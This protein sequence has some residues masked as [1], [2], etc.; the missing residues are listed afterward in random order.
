M[1]YKGDKQYR[2][3][4]YEYSGEGNYFVS[5]CTYNRNEYSG[6]IISG[7]MIISNAG[8]IADK[9]WNEI[10]GKFENVKLDAYQIMP[11]HFHGI[12]SIRRNLT[13]LPD[14]QVYQIQLKIKRI[15]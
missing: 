8:K 11:D 1:L 9:N 14:G 3:P 10:P 7:K 4:G 5:I 12:I 13:R 6:K 2:L 15:S